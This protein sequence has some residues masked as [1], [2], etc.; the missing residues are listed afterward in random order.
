MAII[1]KG[2]HE[3]KITVFSVFVFLF[4]SFTHPAFSWETLKTDHFTV[5][6]KP[7]YEYQTRDFLKALEYYRPKVENLIQNQAYHLPIIIDDIGTISNGTTNPINNRIYLFTYPP[8]ASSLGTSVQNWATYV[9][10]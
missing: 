2:L 1:K 6:Y 7:E 8:S 5:F 3:K 10:V 4:I 9:G